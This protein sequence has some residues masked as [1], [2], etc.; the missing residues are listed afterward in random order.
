MKV[1]VVGSALWKRPAMGMKGTKSGVGGQFQLQFVFSFIFK[2]TKL[3][4]HGCFCCI[5]LT[6]IFCSTESGML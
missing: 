3:K 5:L 2:S 6:G 1:R 4:L